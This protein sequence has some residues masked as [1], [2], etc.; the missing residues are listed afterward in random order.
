MIIGLIGKARTGKTTFA[1]YL[2]KKYKFQN[3][4][5]ADPIKEGAKIMFLLSEEQVY[6]N[7]K[8]IVDPRWNKTPRQILQELGTDL[9]REHF[10]K[11]IWIKRL[12]ME[13][14]LLKKQKINIVVSDIRFP[15]EAEAVKSMGGHL[16]KIIKSDISTSDLHVSEQLVDKIKFDSSIKNDFKIKDFYAQ[17][18][19]LMLD[20]L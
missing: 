12:R 13:A 1:D 3:L 8:E 15:N 17:I 19:R 20:I 5:F 10:G 11:D 7:L 2:T 4:A 14:K 16:I 9:C 18:D 6:G